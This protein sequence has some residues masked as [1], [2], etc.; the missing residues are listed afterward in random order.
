MILAEIITIGDELLIGQVIDTNSAWMGQ[1]LN[2]IGIKV[3]QITSISDDKMHILTTLEEAKKRADVILITG[4][5]GPTK[6]DITKK[7]LC[8]YFGSELVFHEPSF[9][10]IEEIFNSRG[11]TITET[12]RLQAYVPANCEVLVNKNGT[13]PGM[14]FN[15]GKKIIVSMPGVPNEMKGLMETLVIPQLKSKFNLAPIVHKTILTQGI[16]E[17]FLSDLIEKWELA[18]PVYM[19]LAYLPSAGTVRLRITASGKD[20][21]VLRKEVESQTEELKKLIPE[22]I[23]GY[24]TD[25]LESLIGELLV[26]KNKTLSTAE[27][28]TGG[29]IAHKITSV[30]GS[31]RYYMGSVLPY[32]NDLKTGLLKVD[33][34]LIAKHGAVSQ[35]V[36]TQMAELARKMLKTDYAIATSGIAGPSGGSD[37]KPVGT[38]W[39]GIAGPEKTKAWKVQ[40][41]SNR[42]RVITETALHALNGLRKELLAT[43]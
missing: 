7:T 5:L 3:K 1:K 17:S 29:F 11:R 13:A 31:S 37:L 33:P 16:G 25:Q 20:A 12:N 30:P 34:E 15:D 28:C 18:L 2:E 19:K 6:D 40:L 43:K 22:Y 26:Q 27:S 39:I 21:D 9:K 8:D 4:G 38:V 41:G 42:L 24:E 36:V 10:V 14:W 35:E 23:F 32:S